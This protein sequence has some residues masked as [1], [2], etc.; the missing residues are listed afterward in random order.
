MSKG[1]EHTLG[2]LEQHCL[3]ACGRPHVSSRAGS[4]SNGALT[5]GQALGSPLQVFLSLQWVFLFILDVV[6][7]HAADPHPIVPKGH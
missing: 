7:L 6:S 3:W 5:R 4:R 1:I 2:M